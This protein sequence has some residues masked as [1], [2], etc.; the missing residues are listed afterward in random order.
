[1]ENRYFV[2][3]EVYFESPEFKGINGLLAESNCLYV[4]DFANGSN[5]KLSSD[6]KLNKFGTS[7]E[8]ADGVVVYEKGYFVSN[9][10]GEVYYMSP[11][12]E[13]KKI[14]DTKDQKI[15]AA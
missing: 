3:C 11:S 12:G 1:M 13:A 8:G 9:W 15:S 14:L 4:V 7:S 5:Y 10:H 6:K 2:A